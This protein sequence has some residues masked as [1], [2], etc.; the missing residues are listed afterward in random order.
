MLEQPD[1][2]DKIISIYDGNRLNLIQNYIDNQSLDKTDKNTR[3]FII[4]T[5]D[6]LI[7]LHIN[8]SVYTQKKP[9]KIKEISDNCK[10][11]SN[12]FGKNWLKDIFN[13]SPEESDNFYQEKIDGYNIYGYKKEHVNS[14]TFASTSETIITNKECNDLLKKYDQILKKEKIRSLNNNQKAENLK[15]TRNYDID[16]KKCSMYMAYYYD[17]GR[18]QISFES[19]IEDSV[20]LTKCAK[21]MENVLVSQASNRH[22]LPC[23]TN[24][25]TVLSK[26]YK[27]LRTLM[28]GK[29][30]S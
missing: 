19:K 5:V 10:K 18:F 27:K 9:D 3:L 13:T 28:P 20:L 1:L 24:H 26:T 22:S 25:E 30:V 7:D 17:L 29:N 16:D 15:T 2:I 6:A 4:D 21:T 12:M 11:L 23:K 8:F 14:I